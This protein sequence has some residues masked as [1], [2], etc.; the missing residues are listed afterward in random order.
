M[1]S[2][3][4][5]RKKGGEAKSEEPQKTEEEDTKKAQDLGPVDLDPDFKVVLGIVLAFASMLG[6]FF[7]YKVDNSKDGAF[8]SWI[9]VNIV[10]PLEPWF[11]K[12]KNRYQK[13]GL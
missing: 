10:R 12:P 5:E 9:N 1:S 7:Y 3:L 4:R 6:L 11:T 8:A 2:G 13:K